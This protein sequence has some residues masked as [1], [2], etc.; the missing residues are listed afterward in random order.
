MQFG[1]RNRKG[2]HLNVTGPDFTQGAPYRHM[3]A[4]PANRPDW[5]YFAV[6]FNTGHR[7]T[8]DM[9]VQL[10]G[11]SGTVTGTAWFD[12]LCLVELPAPP[13]VDDADRRAAEWL[14]RVGGSGK[15]KIVNQ[16][17]PMEFNANSSLPTEPFHL[18][19]V[20]LFIPNGQDTPEA[21]HEYL[22]PLRHVENLWINP[23]R[24]LEFL[25]EW[26]QLVSFH[27]NGP[28]TIDNID[29]L[30]KACPDLEQIQLNPPESRADLYERMAKF[31]RL[32]RLFLFHAKLDAA[33]YEALKT[34]PALS[35]LHLG[36]CNDTDEA[37]ADL[38][39]A[40]PGL[41]IT[42]HRF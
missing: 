32:K 34:Y 18:I 40:L 10:G 16:S 39:A 12:D 30:L 42:R 1:E 41:N 6:V 7:A 14:Q 26:S 15:L 3:S 27:V 38:K 35:W 29:T 9:A 22:S 25:D 33:D 37:N 8:F 28:L 19:D 4:P 31:P 5:T 24:D 2:A 11:Q 23:K 13:A 17:E 20:G 21:L 36:G